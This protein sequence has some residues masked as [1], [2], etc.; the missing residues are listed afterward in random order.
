MADPG[1]E[2][3]AALLAAASLFPVPDGARFSYGTAGFRAE[4]ST[5]AP[6]VCRAGIV[7]A[8]RSVKLGG[9]AVGLV[10]TASHNPVDD[11]GVKIVDADGGMMSQAW[12]PFSDALANAPTPDALL[13]VGASHPSKMIQLS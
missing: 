9:A 4:G 11:N 6:A 5:M 12:E 10:I 1:G 2:Q 3:R 7:A 13:Q 8:L